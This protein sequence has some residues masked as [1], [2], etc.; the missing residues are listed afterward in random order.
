M[1]KITHLVNPHVA[2]AVMLRQKKKMLREDPDL[3]AT[4]LKRY[5]ANQAERD[6]AA[7]D[8]QRARKDLRK[9]AAKVA[10]P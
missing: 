8:R 6:K 1:S 5:R 2:R 3:L 9:L 10:K 4:M 7:A